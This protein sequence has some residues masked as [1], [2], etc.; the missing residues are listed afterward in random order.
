M[1]LGLLVPLT[2]GLLSFI[3]L[4]SFYCGLAPGPMSPMPPA[5]SV[6]PTWISVSFLVRR[7][8]IFV[9]WP[10]LSPA[11]RVHCPVSFSTLSMWMMMPVFPFA[12][13]PGAVVHWALVV[14]PP[15]TLSAVGPLVFALFAPA[16]VLIFRAAVVDVMPPFFTTFA[17]IVSLF[18]RSS[19]VFMA[20][21][22]AGLVGYRRS[23]VRCGLG[24]LW[25]A[26]CIGKVVTQNRSVPGLHYQRPVPVCLHVGPEGAERW[27]VLWLQLIVQGFTAGPV[28]PPH[29]IG[30]LL[31]YWHGLHGL[32]LLLTE[33]QE[34]AHRLTPA[35]HLQN[36]KGHVCYYSKCDNNQRAEEEMIL[37]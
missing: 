4:L 1:V 17:I 6:G 21:V 7:A 33:G 14:V 35:R 12:G 2:G 15:A 16:T 34:E 5:F 31:P 19:A 13:N 10:P 9:P 3:R 27:Q 11:A 29:L 23:C 22:A 30:P 36:Q 32:L 25:H 24:L 20:M 28:V 8:S 26:R 37:E 18:S